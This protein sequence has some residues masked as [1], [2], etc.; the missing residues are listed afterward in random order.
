MKKKISG[1][2]RTENVE[3]RELGPYTAAPDQ[4]GVSPQP[5]MSDDNPS[6]LDGQIGGLPAGAET[7]RGNDTPSVSDDTVMD[8]GWYRHRDWHVRV[9]VLGGGP[10]RQR[11]RWFQGWSMGWSMR[12]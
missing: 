1:R 8:T 9:V 3:P 4:S 6:S 7:E 11:R 10:D 2:L 12:K 5:V